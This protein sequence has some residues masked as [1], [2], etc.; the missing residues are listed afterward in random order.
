MCHHWFH[1][2]TGY[3]PP[4]EEELVAVPMGKRERDGEEDYVLA[5]RTCFDVWHAAARQK[6]YTG[7]PLGFIPKMNNVRNGGDASAGSEGAEGVVVSQQSDGTISSLSGTE[8]S[9]HTPM[10]AT[11]GVD[12]DALAALGDAALP[13]PVAGETAGAGYDGDQSGD[14]ERGIA[15]GSA[16]TLFP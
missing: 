10:E 11:D 4:G 13:V 12:A 8:R 14:D 6:A 7:V 1:N 2:V 16:R 5:K 9:T 15:E 3:L